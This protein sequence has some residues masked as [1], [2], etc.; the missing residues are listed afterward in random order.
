MC[1]DELDLNGPV[2]VGI[3]VQHI[4]PGLETET[5]IWTVYREGLL[6]AGF[7][8][9]VNTNGSAVATG[10]LDHVDE[11]VAV[12]V[13]AGCSN[14]V[15]ARAQVENVLKAVAST[16]DGPDLSDREA[17]SLRQAVRYLALGRRNR[18]RPR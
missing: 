8:A 11:E 17:R 1:L 16:C 3:H 10:Q 2:V 7:P 12:R 5:T 15:D 18:I 4:I 13:G 9:S 14:P 6:P